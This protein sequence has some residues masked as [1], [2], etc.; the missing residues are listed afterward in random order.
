MRTS[1]EKREEIIFEKYLKLCIFDR[2]DG[3]GAWLISDEGDLPKKW[4]RTENR[5]LFPSTCDS[6]WS[7]IDIICTSVWLIT[8]RDDN[9]SWFPKLCLT[10]KKEE[11]YLRL[12]KTVEYIEIGYF[13]HKKI[14]KIGLWYQ[15]IEKN[16]NNIYEKSHY[17]ER[18]HHKKIPDTQGFFTRN[19]YDY[20]W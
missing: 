20:F 10:H 6:Y 11:W 1:L 19:I 9:L 16:A 2:L 17:K 3:R 4:T 8:H 18:T 13:W 15:I 14:F 5:E 12:R 7:T